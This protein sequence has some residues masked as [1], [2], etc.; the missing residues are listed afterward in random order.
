[1]LKL[2]STVCASI[3]VFFLLP[4]FSVPKEIKPFIE[5]HCIDCHDAE[6]KEGGLDLESLDFD[7]TSKKVFKHWVHVYDQVISGDMPP[8]K[9]KRPE[10]KAKVDF[11]EFLEKSLLKT[12]VKEISQK[13]RSQ[14]RRL[15]R[16]EYENSIR[17]LLKAPWLNISEH[18]PEDGTAHLFNKV[19]GNLD[20]SHVQIESYLKAA[21][22]AIDSALS[23][24]AYPT[25]T[26]KY[27][28][29][30][31]KG[32]T[33]NFY[34]RFGQRSAT[35]SAVPL[36]GHK[37]ELDIIRK[38][39]KLTVGA[40]NPKV[41]EEEAVGYFS[42]TYTATTKYDFR[43]VDIPAD[44]RYKIRIKS[45]TFM[46]GLNGRSGGPEH[47]LESGDQKIWRPDRNVIFK[48]K[49]TEPVTIYA[50][51]SSG[52]SRWAFTYDARPDPEIAESEIYLEKGEMIRP[53]AGRLVRTR[54]GWKGNPNMTEEGIPGFAL[55]WLEVTGPVY[56]SWPPKNYR[57]LFGDMPFKVAKDKSVT[58]VSK[59][60]DS[61]ARKLIF[62]FM[63]NAYRHP[64]LEGEAEPYFS[65]YKKSMQAGDGFTNAIKAA[66]TTI[67]CS[68]GFIYLDEKL[69][70][71]DSFALSSRLS[72]FLWNSSPDEELRA[73]ASTGKLQERDTLTSQ[74]NRML[75]DKKFQ[76]FIDQFLDYWLNLRDIHLNPP[77]ASLYPDYYLDDQLTEASIF[78]TRMYFKSLI[79]NDKSV[80]YL[81]DSDYTFLN[82]RLAKHY[83]IPMPEGVDL[84]KVK[85]PEDSPRGGL[86]TQSSILRVTAN[87][88]TTSPVIRGAW[89]AER[90][91]GIEV[92][93]PPSG[94]EAIEPDT[95][96]ATTIREQ[97]EKHNSNKSCKNCHLKFDP[98]G[99]SLENF[100]VAGG[101]QTKYR[102]LGEEGEQ[103]EGVGKN[104]HVFKFRYNQ[105]VDAR[106]ELVDGSKFNNITELK[107]LLL[108]DK[109]KL[110]RNLVNRLIVYSTG[111]PVSF[112]DREEVENIL[113]KSKESGYGLR[114]LI[115]EVIYSKLFRYK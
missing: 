107:K 35:R 30:D 33:R 108:K 100:D 56:E 57:A 69:G 19:G 68:P 97:L 90:I 88:T 5:K 17:E 73:L 87:G 27:Y 51:K 82:E 54:P 62:N 99:F 92:P 12:D 43:N 39:Q 52:D 70:E 47:G 53:D 49:R 18:L 103:T 89:I 10:E 104:G 75:N 38:K 37:P 105:D 14:V 77:D 72:Y 55:N 45:Y 28:A 61:D 3:F 34:Y 91:L 114:T 84:Q 67:L 22:M 113:D 86:L 111:S 31:E 40:E 101:W 59:N 94:V 20:I 106:G 15:N 1:M 25:K 21:E 83:G 71:L 102:S 6:M 41:R 44:G 50:L 13:G 110:A 63:K 64:V 29:R 115:K 76:H 8:K 32:M 48:G 46:A 11:L 16:Y 2:Y 60:P 85:L 26:K 65:I 66:Y 23:S 80:S 42:G 95:R 9:K 96:G 78:E 4:A 112:G 36:L 93:A 79:Q 7:L 98:V 24:V 81:V 74:I 109:R 58:V